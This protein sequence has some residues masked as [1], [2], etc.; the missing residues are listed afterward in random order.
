MAE[1]R[2]TLQE[3]RL[4]SKFRYSAKVDAWLSII[5]LDAG[6][7]SGNSHSNLIAIPVAQM[8]SLVS[9]DPKYVHFSPYIADTA[10]DSLL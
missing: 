9:I 3:G 2:V 5:A 6:G 8:T 7:A 10:T 4:L 1:C